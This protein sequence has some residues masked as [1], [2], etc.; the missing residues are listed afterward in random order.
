MLQQ[1]TIQD[2]VH[3]VSVVCKQTVPHSL[4]IANLRRGREVA[5]E[6]R[7]IFV[8]R[9]GERVSW[10]RNYP[11]YAC[12]ECYAKVRHIPVGQVLKAVA[13]RRFPIWERDN[14]GGLCVCEVCGETKPIIA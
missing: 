11:H 5:H 12:V 6:S 2:I 4:M 3:V 14:T 13:E 9:E 8:K 10:F 7:T 1:S